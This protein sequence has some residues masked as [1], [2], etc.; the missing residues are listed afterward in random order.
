MAFTFKG[1]TYNIAVYRKAVVAFIGATVAVMAAVIA[2]GFIPVAA[3]AGV[4]V[5]VAVL[6]GV[7]AFLTKNAK[8]ID[9]LDGYDPDDVV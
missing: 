4:G 2:T 7:A 6:T 1:R 9:A 8:M 5:V 3:A